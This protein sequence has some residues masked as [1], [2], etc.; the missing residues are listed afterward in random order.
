VFPTG[1][2]A[3]KDLTWFD[4]SSDRA[5]SPDG[6]LMLFDESGE[7]GGASGGAYLR[8]TDGSPAVRLG[9]ASGSHCRPTPRGR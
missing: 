6:K 5:L 2:T 7:G 8:P 1:E 3:G 9:D 4:W